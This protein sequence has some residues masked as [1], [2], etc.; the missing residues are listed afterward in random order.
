[1]K[2]IDP[3][4]YNTFTI[5]DSTQIKYIKDL[6]EF[7]DNDLYT[8]KKYQIC[9]PEVYQVISSHDKNVLVD[10]KNSIEGARIECLKYAMNL[11]NIH[12]PNSMKELL[13][14]MY[15]LKMYYQDKFYVRDKRKC[16]DEYG[17]ENDDYNFSDYMRLK[18]FFQSSD[19]IKNVESFGYENVLEIIKKY[20]TVACSTTDQGNRRRERFETVKRYADYSEGVAK[21]EEA[22]DNLTC[23]RNVIYSKSSA[24]KTKKFTK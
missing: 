2:K 24:S 21:I 23:Y 4:I 18:M 3:I 7:C 12:N 11:L 15:G 6:K 20:L 14:I 19:I 1:M 13:T 17:Y 22:F 5:E 8:L 9:L 16:A 10:F